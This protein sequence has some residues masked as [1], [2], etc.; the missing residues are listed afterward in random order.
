M[1]LGLAL[2]NA[3]CFAAT[4]PAASASLERPGVDF[5]RDVRPIFAKHCYHCHGP[6][7]Q[8]SS[9]R[10]D[11]KAVVLRGGDSGT[12]AIVA[13]R[14]AESPLLQRVLGVDP[15][16]VMPPKG[17]RLSPAEI[18]VLRTWIDL[19]APWPD[20][21]SSDAKRSHWAFSAPRKTE[22]PA[23]GGEGWVRNSIDRFVLARLEKEGLKPSPPADRVTLVRRLSLDLTGLPPSLE[24]V[25]EFVNDARPDAYER[26]VE[27]LL[28]SPHYGERWGR[29]WLDVARY[30][31]SNGY[32]KD[33]R[34]SI[35][36]YR[37]YVIRALN[38]DL[39]FDRFTLEQLAGD[40]LPNPT[41]DQR[42]ATGF[43]R[44]SMMNQE[45]GIEP[46]QFRTEAMIDR[47]DAVGKAWLGLTIACAQ[48]HN[49]KF[50]PMSQQEYFE[51][52]A[53]LNN[54]DEPFIEVPT[55][56]QERQREA[57]RSQ[58]R[59]LEA[60]LA[61]STPQVKERMAAWEKELVEA[62]GEWTLLDPGEW[63]N[64]AVKYE[65]QSDGSLLGGGDIKPGGVTH[66]WVDTQQTNITG[67]QL[68]ALLHPN[69]PYGGPGLVAKGSYLLKE[70]TVQ[71]YAIHDPQV[72]NVVR[73][74]RAAADMEAPGF[75]VTN[76]IDGDLDKGGWTAAIAPV[77]R[78][79]EH[80]AV[81]ECAEPIAGF[82][83]G[84]RLHIS[85]HQKHSSGDGHS[86]EL[87]KDSQFDCHSLGR[88]R[89]SMTTAPGPLR[90]DPLT[91]EQRR[92]LAIPPD[93]R[94]PQQQQAL[95]NVWRF[96]VPSLAKANQEIDA[97]WA[98]WP[99]PA[100]T[101]ALQQRPEPRVTRIFKRGDWQ[102]LGEAVR[103]QVPSFLHPLPEGAPPNRL[104]LAQW[105][106]DRRSPT[107]ARVVV[108]RVWQAY[109][110]QGLFTTPEDIGT[111]V[112]PPSHPELLDWL[113]C[114]FMDRGWSFKEMHR[115]ITGS[116]TYRQASRVTPDLYTLDPYNRLLARSPRFRV[117]GEIVQD[118]ALAA[119]GL[120]NP[121]IGG[122]SVYPPIPGN[123]ADQVYG[124]FSWPES[125]GEDRYRRA[126]YTFWKR[127]LPYPALLAF[128][129]PPA[130]TSCPRRVRSNTPLQALTTLN[131]KTFV[132]AAQALGLKIY[133]Q[134]G[135]DDRSRMAYAF[136]VCT[137]RSPTPREMES[138]LRFHREQESYFANRTAAAVKVSVPDLNKMPEDVNLHR[139][140]AW[141]MVSRALLNLD[142]TVTRE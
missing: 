135:A 95:F 97:V 27:R 62:A 106:V 138:L 122:P 67:F 94:S 45:G 90:V 98:K 52:F 21:G 139:V 134:G 86:G 40:L 121:K 111:R 19:G 46:E 140:A 4:E 14:S 137:G 100:T 96:T 41:L 114:E 2:A 89:M 59:D 85:V 73:F 71:A 123:V 49:H 20:E 9:L 115:L 3:L 5:L 47:M 23:V 107:T 44:N 79:S 42:V 92:W 113:A 70:L 48:C 37:D 55:P 69:L 119:S 29:H 124:G 82:R 108:N 132:E 53:F 78:H 117:E 133:R 58:V 22:P 76:A 38:Q 118:I 104:G 88:F 102:R 105:L 101:L 15:D 56:E 13:G 99:Y 128:D 43:L 8:K 26:L 110:G 10:L 103:P 39:A 34:R 93:Q 57:I 142:E 87:D 11:E 129:A 50:D 36:P 116:A 72:T 84:T 112:E 6:E 35:W 54:D 61:Q 66:L 127:A 17:E 32:E 25:D 125:K 7:E 63:M 30:A 51:L 81:F 74:A 130:E 120:L 24:E 31:D 80:R 109:F 18:S 1:G 136:R 65:K 68:E 91:A 16:E 64:F 83:G 75:S 131:E 12:P 126:M 28:A 33:A 77:R 60:R 141:A